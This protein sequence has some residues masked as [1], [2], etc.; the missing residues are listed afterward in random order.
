MKRA[1]CSPHRAPSPLGH[2]VALLEAD[3]HTL[4]LAS[5]ERHASE[6]P[7]VVAASSAVEAL[8]RGTGKAASSAAPG[9]GCS[10]RDRDTLQ[11]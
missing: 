1:L 10:L 5:L 9:D 11:P 8:A 4:V 2:A 7:V 3:C 6:V